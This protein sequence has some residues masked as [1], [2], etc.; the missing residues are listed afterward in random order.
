MK[1][2]NNIILSVTGVVFITALLWWSFSN[3]KLAIEASIPG[4]DNRETD[5]AGLNEIIDIGAFFERFNEIEQNL[6]DTWPRF[7]G[8]EFDNIKKPGVDLIDHF[9]ADDPKIQWTADLGEGHAGPAVYK[10]KVYVLDYDEVTKADMLRCFSLKDG[11]ELWRRWYNVNIKR[12]HGMSRT[13]PV[14]TEDYIL[15]IGPRSHVMCL[16]RET[17]DF[18]W[19]INIEKEYDTAVPFWYT[20]QC[21]MIDE[22]KAI[23]ATGGKAILIAVDCETGELVWETP[24]PGKWKMSHSSVMPWEYE[25]TKMY[26]YSAVGGICGIAA[27]GPDAGKVLWESAKWGCS[28]VAP[29]PVCMPDGKVFLTAGYG[30]G[31]MVFQVSGRNGQFSVEKLY[32]YKPKDGLACEQQTPIYHDGMLFGIL[33]K[34]AG[35]SRNQF[36]CVDPADCRT[37]VWTS[38]KEHRF[39]LGPYMIAD[40]KFF[41]LNDDG[42]LSITQPSRNKF[43]LLD[44]IQVFEAHDAWAPLAV[45]DGYL[46]LRDDHRMV[47][48]DI[49][50][51]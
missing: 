25:G 15:T 33:P 47:C 12:N 36:V 18:R 4:M 9:S 5:E 35:P 20:G 27:E 40:G 50:K 28:V 46:I 16:D 49:R 13:I 10:G 14:V 22:G 34:D 8:L 3:P 6:E 48:M 30:A 24:N 1:N 44:Q 37:F 7:R 19:G 32:E 41:I 21:P 31:S 2:L 38:G 26:V 43:I 39:G 51:Q 45:A 11:T 17:G 23:I 42:T 29:S